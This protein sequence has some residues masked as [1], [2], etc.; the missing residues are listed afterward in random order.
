MSDRSI[1]EKEEKKGKLAS[2]EGMGCT[3]TTSLTF[4]TK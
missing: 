3:L 4:D 1:T 2:L